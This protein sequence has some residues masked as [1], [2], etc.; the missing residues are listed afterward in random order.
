[1]ALERVYY[2]AALQV[3]EP[4]R[5]VTRTREDT[6]AVRRHGAVAD[7]ELVGLAPSL[8]LEAF[9][10]DVPLRGFDP[11][12]HVIEQVVGEGGEGLS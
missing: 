4:Q 10:A 9:P 2:L 7:A 1:M 3:P 12:R 8:A 5:L 11:R 6:A